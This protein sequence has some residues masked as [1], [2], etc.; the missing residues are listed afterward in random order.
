M[1]QYND[2]NNEINLKKTNTRDHISM[3]DLETAV[4][5]QIRPFEFQTDN[6]V[7]THRIGTNTSFSQTRTFRI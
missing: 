5:Q 6:L 1:C 2:E 7:K 4:Q 3:D